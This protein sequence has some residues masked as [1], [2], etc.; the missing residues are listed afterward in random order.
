ME[1]LMNAL[2]GLVA[3]VTGAGG[4]IG[5]ASVRAMTQAGATV[6]AVDVNPDSA[7]AVADEVGDSVR[8]HAADVSDEAQVR[9]MISAALTAFGGIDILF[10]NAGLVGLEHHTALTDLDVE[11]WDHTFAVNSRGVM[12]GCKHAIPHLIA[13]GGGVIINTSSDGALTGDVVNFAYA[14]SKGAVAV[15]SRYVATRYGKENVRCNSIAPGIHV[16]EADRAAVGDDVVFRTEMY[17][18]LEEHCLLPRLGT[19][20]DVADLA[21]FLGSPQAR[22]ITGQLI[23]VDG[24]FLAHAPHLADT[25]RLGGRAYAQG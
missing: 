5:R 10:N 23:Q 20:E 21:V 6:L 15:L 4:R 7:H 17:D 22:Y 9:S 13:R 24:G 11:V 25:R 8:A 16:T 12:L 3:I 14:A 19:P 18:M 2:D 1:Y